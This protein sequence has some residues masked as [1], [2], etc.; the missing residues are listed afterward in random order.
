MKPLFKAGAKLLSARVSS[1]YGVELRLA[2]EIDKPEVRK[3]QFTAALIKRSKQ[4][5]NRKLIIKTSQGEWLSISHY[6][7]FSNCNIT[8]GNDGQVLHI[9]IG[10]QSR[11]NTE[12][13]SFEVN[14]NISDGS[15]LTP[16]QDA[17]ASLHLETLNDLLLK[18]FFVK[19]ATFEI[20][21][22]HPDTW[23]IDLSTAI[24]EEEVVEM[25]TIPAA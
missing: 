21:Q 14:S 25:T 1:I 11:I 13:L 20:E 9:G 7:T 17:A 22:D 8:S 4:N 10:N 23:C 12:R 18:H 3:Q 5:Q 24:Y 6:G 15:V 16:I 2:V 19:G